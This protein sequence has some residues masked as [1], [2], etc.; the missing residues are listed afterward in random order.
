MRCLFIVIICL[1][2]AEFACAQS[3]SIINVDATGFPMMKATFYAFDSTG[4]EYSPNTDD[5]LLTENGLPRTIS[6]VICPTPQPPKALSAVLVIDVSNSMLSKSNQISNMELAKKGARAWV[7]KLQFDSSECAITSFDDQNYLNRDFSSDRTQLLNAITPL[8]P[9]GGTDYDAAFINQKAGGLLISKTGSHQKVIVFL[10]DGQP[11]KLP[12][13]DSIVNEANAQNCTIFCITIGINAPQPLKDIARR[14]GGLVFDNITST[15]EIEDVYLKILSII[16]NYGPCT[17]EWQSGNGCKDGITN[18]ELQLLPLNSRTVTRYQPPS[19]SIGYIEFSPQSIV[20][21]NVPPN[22]ATPATAIV[23]VTARNMDFNVE[24]IIGSNSIFTISETNFKLV[25]DIPKDLTVNFIPEDSGYVFGEFTF[26]STPCTA[27][28][29]TSGGFPGVKPKNQTL[30]LK[31]PNGGEKFAVGNDALISW[32]G[33]SK[34][35]TVQLEYSN[36]NGKSWKFI[37]DKATGLQYL[38]KNIPKPESNQCKVRVKQI[39]EDSIVNSNSGTLQFDL[40]GHTGDVN[41]VSWSPDGKKVATASKDNTAIVWD[42]VS[43]TKLYTLAGHT[44]EVNSIQW[45]PNGTKIVTGSFDRRFIIWDSESG[46]EI[47]NKDAING[48]IDLVAW[49]PDGTKIAIVSYNTTAVVW[50]TRQGDSHYTLNGHTQNIST[51][52]WSPDGSKIASAGL[53]KT[54]I[55]WNTEFGEKLLTLKEH[56]GGLKSVSWSP[57][58]SKIVTTSIDK[59]AI[60]WDVVKGISLSTLRGH[61]NVVEGSCWSPDGSKVATSSSDGRAIIWDGESGKL[62]YT[63]D[64]HNGGINSINWNY[65]GSKIA[66]ASDDNTTIIWDVKKGEK[67][68]T[69]EGHTKPVRAVHWSPDGSKVATAS[70]DNTVKIWF[71]GDVNIALQEEESDNVF[72][73]VEPVAEAKS[74]DLLRCLLGS[75]KDSTVSEFISNL[76]AYPCKIDSI[77]F[78][79]GDAA[80]FSLV[81]GIPKYEL[82]GWESKA[83][84]FRFRPTDMRVHRA[85]INVLSQSKITKQIIEAEGILPTLEVIGNIIDFGKVPIN[86]Q[87]DIHDAITVKNINASSVTIND[88]RIAGPN[89]ISFSILDSVRSFTLNPN[90]TAKLNVRFAPKDVSRTSGRLI[91]DYN[92]IAS[93]ATVQL[94]GEGFCGIDSTRILNVGLGNEISTPVGT[95]VELPLIMKLLPGQQRETIASRFFCTLSFDASIL[96]P[97]KPLSLGALEGNRRIVKMDEIRSVNSDTMIKLPFLAML[98]SDSVATVRINSFYFDDTGCPIT[99]NIDSVKVK[100]TDFCTAGGSTRFLTTAPI[101]KVIMLPN[102]PEDNSNILITLT[103]DSPIT[104][105]IHDT[106]GREIMTQRQELLEQGSHL[107]AFDC[108]QLSS[109]IYS[110]MLTTRSEVKFLQFVKR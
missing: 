22:S 71:V 6:T 95:I 28:L 79:G 8:E 99:V 40:K 43:G 58:G 63:L 47:T 108:T 93:P 11:N 45:S 48:L 7:N 96:F 75:V 103:E 69:F 72:S 110:L 32:E 66:T 18:V 105:S 38:W 44:D 67:L 68:Y 78:T 84:E 37:T 2:G 1:L 80:A 76:S 51:V 74:I 102:P 56:S 33:V 16:E 3:L 57:D 14:T 41:A 26:Q 46:K 85:I 87:R 62:L 21:K 55:I 65:T 4:R 77:Y 70:S 35:D 50:D 31:E 101:T 73:I 81:S 106:F 23:R 36:D 83:V 34:S 20:F 86:N 53:D 19:T 15:K 88:I 61:E 64:G 29:H 89:N 49:S 24:N 109:G 104:I 98:G 90:D 42:A 97:M 39:I 13:V 27:I 9:Q 59:T 52:S 17:I 82:G 94:F 12:Q 92:G 5:F 10:T 91:F 107:Q 54:S 30:K 100:L 60:I 25:K